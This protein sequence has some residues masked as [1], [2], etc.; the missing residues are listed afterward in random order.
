MT[1]IAFYS[2]S[3]MEEMEKRLIQI[4]EHTPVGQIIEIARK[5]E[6][7]ICGNGILI[8]IEICQMIKNIN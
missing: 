5:Y 8:K 1:V 7:T 6:N 4:D 3:I 2:G